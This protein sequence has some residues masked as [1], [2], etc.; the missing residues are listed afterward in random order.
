MESSAFPDKIDE[1]ENTILKLRE[2]TSDLDFVPIVSIIA[3]GENFW[4]NYP[5]YLF[6]NPMK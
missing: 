3:D 1:F 6:L 2:K 5:T 4:E